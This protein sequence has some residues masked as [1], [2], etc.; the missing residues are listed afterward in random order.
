MVSK[1]IGTIW[2]LTVLETSF[3]ENTSYLG[4]LTQTTAWALVEKYHWKYLKGSQRA[5]D[6]QNRIFL[7]PEAY[8]TI[9]FSDFFGGLNFQ[10]NSHTYGKIECKNLLDFTLLT[11]KFHNR[12]F[13]SK[14]Y[15]AIPEVWTRSTS[16]FISMFMILHTN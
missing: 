2:E 11:L 15:Y 3:F 12:L 10:A 1:I 7:T 13:A 8:I 5:G 4:M 14:Q 9:L 6:N 16:C